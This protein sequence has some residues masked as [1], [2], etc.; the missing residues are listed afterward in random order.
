MKQIERGVTALFDRLGSTVVGCMLFD[1]DRRA[2]RPEHPRLHLAV[3]LQFW[4]ADAGQAMCLARFIADLE[5]EFRDDVTLVLVRAHD[6]PL[7]DYLAATAAYCEAKMSVLHVQAKCSAP[8]HY[9]GAFSL[10]S[11]ARAALC[12][13]FEA[14][15]F[16]EPDGVPLRW[17]WIDEWKR[18]IVENTEAGFHVT[19]A[20]MEGNPQ[21]GHPTHVNGSLAATGSFLREHP[22][23][24][25]CL[26][27]WAWDIYHGKLLLAHRGPRAGVVNL[28]GAR[29]VSL[30]VF[31]T[32]GREAA[33]LASV[34]DES[35]WRCAQTLLSFDEG[36]LA[37]LRVKLRDY[38]EAQRR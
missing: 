3:A 35:A 14:V 2:S 23:L 34:K 22:E 19:G 6:M 4:Q 30:S 9:G 21:F 31:K 12:D 20:R 7:D 8:G 13:E 17:D 26:P 16:V 38:L 1:A 29:K 37:A 15:A 11:A 33:W 32:L 5:P 25:T 24:G 27:G 18:A 36:V 10:W 28:Y